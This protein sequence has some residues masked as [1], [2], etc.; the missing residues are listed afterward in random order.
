MAE[1][2]DAECLRLMSP[3]ANFR[4]RSLGGYMR[5]IPDGDGERT[6]HI[7]VRPGRGARHSFR[8]LLNPLDALQP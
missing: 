5:R 2:G 1:K 6:F 3:L 8:M 7:W 4:R